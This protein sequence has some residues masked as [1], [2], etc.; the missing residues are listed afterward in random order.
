MTKKKDP[1][2]KLRY[3]E[4]IPGIFLRFSGAAFIDECWHGLQLGAQHYGYELREV[5]AIPQL[6]YN[7]VPRALQ[8][9]AESWLILYRQDRENELLI[10]PYP[11]TEVLQRLQEARGLRG[12][13]TATLETIRGAPGEQW[14]C[15]KGYSNLRRNLDPRQP[16]LPRL[17][18][19]RF[20]VTRINVSLDS[21]LRPA[22]VRLV[23][24]EEQAGRD[25]LQRAT[26]RVQEHRRNILSL[27]LVTD[28]EDHRQNLLA[29]LE[30]YLVAEN[31]RIYEQ[32]QSGWDRKIV[33]PALVYSFEGVLDKNPVKVKS[34][35]RGDFKEEFDDFKAG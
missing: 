19:G 1:T 9:G 13:A 18:I 20:Q 27:I 8:D 35:K 34:R 2:S 29:E 32:I 25:V 14:Y 5:E 7:L 17:G 6:V 21:L 33:V 3:R 31:L 26:G 28:D 12:H 24:L 22:Q 30:E 10:L 4:R 16:S 23:P 11:D 15:E